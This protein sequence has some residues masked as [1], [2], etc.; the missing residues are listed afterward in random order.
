MRADP[1]SVTQGVRVQV[2]GSLSGELN[3]FDFT[4]VAAFPHKSLDDIPEG[5]PLWAYGIAQRRDA[6]YAEHDKTTPEWRLRQAEYLHDT[7]AYIESYAPS[8]RVRA[9]AEANR[10]DRLLS[11]AL[12]SHVRGEIVTGASRQ[13]RAHIDLLKT[14]AERGKDSYIRGVFVLLQA[15][16][17]MY[18]ETGEV[19]SFQPHIDLCQEA[20]ALFETCGEMDLAVLAKTQ[21][22]DAMA[23]NGAYIASIGAAEAAMDFA[24]R[25]QAWKYAGRLLLTASI[26]AADQGYR[27]GVEEATQKAIRWCQFTGDYWGRVNGIFALARILSYMIPSNDPSRMGIPERYLLEALD[28]AERHGAA[29][30]TARIETWFE[31]LYKKC[32]VDPTDA[33][34]ERWKG[35]VSKSVTEDGQQSRIDELVSQTSTISRTID[36]RI[37]ARL[38]DGVEDSA[39]A[40]FVFDARRNDDGKCVDFLNEYRNRAGAQILNLGPGAVV[41]FSEASSRPLFVGLA[42][43][44]VAAT[45]RRETV[46]DLC[47]VADE[48]N[49][50][51]YRRRV[52]PSGDGAVLTLRDVS[53]ERQ[54]EDALRYAAEL[55]ERAVRTQSEFLANMSHEIRTPINGVL[56]LARLLADA[57]LDAVHR[58]YV[59]DI[60]GSGDILL[61]VI[62][63]VLDLSKIEAHNFQIDLAPV[64]TR[65]MVAGAVRLF[66]GQAREKGIGLSSRVDDALPVMVMADG[67]RIRQVLAN[68]IGNAVKFTSKGSID[69]LAS[70]SG[71][72]LVI[73]VR[74]TG[75]GMSSEELAVV[76]DRFRQA[77]ARSRMLGGTGLGLALSRAIVELMGGTIEAHSSP[78]NG[79]RFVLSIPLVAAAPDAAAIAPAHLMGFVG[80]NVLLVDD[81]RVNTIV[82][83]HALARLGCNVTVAGDGLQALAALEA[84]AFD[85]VMMDVRMPVM[86]G[87]EATRELRRREKDQGRRTAV[88]A[89]TAGALVEER[90][91]CFA[92]G[93]DDY[94]TKPFSDESLRTVL[95]RWLK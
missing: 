58:S 1:A 3:L 15:S 9:I 90:E 68:L 8:N 88:I 55:A 87:L 44:L 34:T 23:R 27:S 19:D 41:M 74:D 67:P 5:D 20:A 80:R 40:F 51:S 72:M 45:E 43:A 38:Q 60:I 14:A 63:N 92:A 85:I 71:A 17:L 82:S 31:W 65:E 7:G 53:A 36:L 69:V 84:G 62:G 28:E 30:L 39:D 4:K 52:V 78:G 93:M 35:R 26:S 50:R 46:E 11:M 75:L 64:E 91:S 22:V 24:S 56:G 13:A 48:E 16:Y 25:H 29:M 54:I 10:D 59:E 81:N 83:E 89:L 33:R 66:Q 42:G 73:E 12:L 86:D 18:A 37:S 2:G 76:F 94:I 57:P 6:L 47:E 79:S 95:A 70:W 32:G 77:N 21:G 61:R 49:R